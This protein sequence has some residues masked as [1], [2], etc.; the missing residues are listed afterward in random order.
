MNLFSNKMRISISGIFGL[1]MIFGMVSCDNIDNTSMP[2]TSEEQV[3]SKY[4][5]LNVIDEGGWLIYDRDDVYE[6][7][8]IIKFHTYVHPIKIDM[9]IDG[10][11]YSSGTRVSINENDDY[12]EYRYVMPA[13]EVTVEFKTDLISYS[14]LL[15][16]YPWLGKL[17]YRETKE[18]VIEQGHLG[19][20]NDEPQ[21]T[22]IKSS[23]DISRIKEELY[24]MDVC[25]VDPNSPLC[26]PVEGGNYIRYTFITETE[27]HIM[28]IENRRLE[29]DGVIYLIYGE[30]PTN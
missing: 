28:Y 12:I 21:V 22:S 26:A 4:Y 17:Q 11:F 2:T 16:L 7:E 1:C 3:V 29:I 14:S 30:Y 25:N 18:L 9:Y 10:E 8:D 19:V 27:T 6:V 5:K 15:R 20:N 23:S 24:D 13:K